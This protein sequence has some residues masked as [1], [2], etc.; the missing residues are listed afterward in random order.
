MTVQGDGPVRVLTSPHR[1][2]C[3]A[4]IGPEP[5]GSRSRDHAAGFARWRPRRVFPAGTYPAMSSR[6]SK[7]TNAHLDPRR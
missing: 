2:S 7:L 1:P 3:V 5:A 6:I 4:A